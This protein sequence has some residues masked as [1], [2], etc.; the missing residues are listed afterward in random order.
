[1]R[2]NAATLFGTVPSLLT[3]HGA[4]HGFIC[5]SDSRTYEGISL[6]VQIKTGVLLEHRV[7]DC[8]VSLCLNPSKFYII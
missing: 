3:K 1:M 7:Y 5:V 2:A 6:S 8:K 4:K